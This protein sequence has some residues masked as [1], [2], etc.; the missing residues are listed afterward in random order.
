MVWQKSLAS[1]RNKVYLNH[2]ESCHEN[3][4]NIDYIK[5]QHNISFASFSQIILM[6]GLFYLMFYKNIKIYWVLGNH[7]IN[8]GFLYFHSLIFIFM[9]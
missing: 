9:D 2:K 6:F 1:L 8:Y 3:F 4:K 7:D 5:S